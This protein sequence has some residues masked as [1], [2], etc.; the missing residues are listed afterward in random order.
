MKVI[1]LD[2]A[3]LRVCELDEF[4]FQLLRM[5]PQVADNTDDPNVSQRLFQQPSSD[6]QQN[7]DWRQFVHPELDR[8]FQQT[9]Q[10]TLQDIEAALANHSPSAENRSVEIPLAHAD[11]WLNCLNRARLA[12]AAQHNLDQSDI[13]NDIKLKFAS[14][15]QLAIFQVHYYGFLQECIL[16]QL[17]ADENS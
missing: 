4:L 14:A 9:S 17:D 16:Q 6:E 2:D 15:R 12:L 1:R 3:T 13:D 7:D 5:A 10:T 8:M 11:D